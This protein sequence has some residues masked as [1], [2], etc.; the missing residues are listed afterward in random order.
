VRRARAEGEGRRRHRPPRARHQ[1]RVHRRVT[2]PARQAR[3]LRL[4]LAVLRR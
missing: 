4:Q 3:R 1:H 2:H